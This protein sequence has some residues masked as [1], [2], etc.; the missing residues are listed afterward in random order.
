MPIAKL[1]VEGKLD[2]EVLAPVLGG[3]PTVQ[4]GGNKHALKPRARIEHC[5]NRIAAG[6]LRDRDFDFDPPAN[7][8]NPTVD[9]ME[10]GVPIG[11]RWCRHEIENYLLEP[12]IIHAATTI[13]ICRD[14]GGHLPSRRENPELPGRAMDDRHR[15]PSI[16]A[17]LRIGN[18]AWFE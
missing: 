2:S 16:A 7:L 10:G 14:Q 12:A 17:A 5:E 1:F 18:P 8:S 13:P 3:S 11:W 9:Y 15:A 4:Q 6:Y